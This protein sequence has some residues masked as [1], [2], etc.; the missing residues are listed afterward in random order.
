MF[1]F[2]HLHLLPIPGTQTWNYEI[3]MILLFFF[4][5][6][7]WCFFNKFSS[8]A[9]QRTAYSKVPSQMAAHLRTGSPQKAG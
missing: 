4:L 6:C 8:A 9:P 3:Q 1:D 5:H 2:A 7:F